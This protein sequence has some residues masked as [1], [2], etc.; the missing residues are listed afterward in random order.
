MKWAHK[1]VIS[2]FAYPEEDSEEIKLGLVKLV[3]L[4]L[5]KEKL[6]VIQTSARG[7]K[8]AKIRIFTINLSRIKH[9]STFLTSLLNKFSEQQRKTLLSQKES[10]LDE[11]LKFFIRLSKSEFL[12]G[13]YVLTDG[14]DCYHIKITIAAFPANRQKALEVV[15]AILT[16]L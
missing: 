2:V 6:S 10:R 8:E 16:T 14:G 3:A 11:E 15:T 12:K 9:I 1:I 13:K 7:F 4:D 5:A